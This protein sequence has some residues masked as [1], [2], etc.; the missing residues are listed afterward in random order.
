MWREKVNLIST[1][2]NHLQ[3][4]LQI[5]KTSK[6]LQTDKLTDKLLFAQTAQKTLKTF[7]KPM[8][9][10]P[11]PPLIVDCYIYS[12]STDKTKI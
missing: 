4:K 7:I 2:T 9:T 12:G 11:I 5:K 8:Q 1:I 3:I 10:S 6:R